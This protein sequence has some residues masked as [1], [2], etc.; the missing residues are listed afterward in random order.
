M[1]MNLTLPILGS[2]FE[3]RTAGAADAEVDPQGNVG[4]IHS[5]HACSTVDG[6]GIRVVLFTT[7]CYFRCLYCHNPDTWKLGNGTRVTAEQVARHLKGY[8]KFLTSAGGG[9]T[10]SGGE[11]LVQRPFVMQ[12]A[13]AGRA[14][15][16]HVALDTNGF[17]GEQLT[18]Q[19]LDDIDLF[20]LDIKESDEQRHLELTAQS[21]APVLE[22]AGRLSARGRP[23]WVRYVLVPGYTARTE[24]IEDLA[25]ILCELRNVE[26]VQV[27]PFHQM[28][29][30]KWAEL[31][32]DYCL[33]DV[34]PPE[35][36]F[37][38]HV[39]SYLNKVNQTKQFESLCS[40]NISTVNPFTKSES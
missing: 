24:S 12:V 35:L 25:R 34:T 37:T 3:L 1:L 33:G 20:L 18:D 10:I 6:P 38:R 7:G 16:L 21:L 11:P 40:L 29:K 32:L 13:R 5:L 27:L 26:R 36:E 14:L 9:L 23:M 17:L 4:F 19:E 8:Q 2:G 30:F 31:N 22:F 28:G 39:E 15:G